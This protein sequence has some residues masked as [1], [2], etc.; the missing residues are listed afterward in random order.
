MRALESFRAQA[1]QF[2][3]LTPF[4][5]GIGTDGSIQVYSGAGSSS[6]VDAVR[7]AGVKLVP[8]IDNSGDGPRVS[9]MLAD[10]SRRTAHVSALA[11]LATDR[12]YDGIDVDYESLAS[13]DRAAFT[14]F[15]NELASAMH[16]RGKMLI[17]TVHAKT[18]EPGTWSGPQAQDYA[19]IGAVADVVRVMA[20]DYHWGGSGPGP[21]APAG[22]VDSVARFAAGAIAPSKVELGMPLYGYDW[23]ASGGTGVVYAEVQSLL[24]RYGASVQWSSENAESWFTY[25]DSGGFSHTVWFSDARSVAARAQIVTRYGLRGAAFWRLGGEDPGVWRSTT[26]EFGGGATPDMT[27]P[28][29][30]IVSPKPKAKLAVPAQTVRYRSSDD[31]GVTTVR[32]YLDKRLVASSSTPNGTFWLSTGSLASGRHLITVQ[33]LD[34]A[35]NARSANVYVK[36]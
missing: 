11:A 31:R 24:A 33:A 16:A 26:V 27:A 35:G 34:A 10:A 32:L 7:A 19:A 36:R 25:R 17:V 12:G 21:I 14:L 20:Y 6:V 2:A 3:E 29:V 1:S 18:S 22:W 28:S 8:S 13:T 5:Y 15:V 4:W 9:R 30:A 23:G